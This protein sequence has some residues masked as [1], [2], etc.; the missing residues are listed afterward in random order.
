MAGLGRSARRFVE[1]LLGDPV[2]P[3]PGG[4]KAGPGVLFGVCVGLLLITM[5][6]LILSYE[7]GSQMWERMFYRVML[8]PGD[9]PPLPAEATKV[10]PGPGQLIEFARAVLV[11]L[12]FFLIV[13]GRFFSTELLALL[14]HAPWADLGPR[15]LGLRSAFR[16][17]FVALAVWLSVSTITHHL[18][19]GPRNLW[20]CNGNPFLQKHLEAGAAAKIRELQ[21]RP[22]DDPEKMNGEP[23]APGAPGYDE[24][25]RQCVLPYRL[26][27]PY[28]FVM[29]VLVGPIV[30]TVCF[31]SVFSSLWAHLMLQPQQVERLSVRGPLEEIENRVRYYKQTYK[32]NVDK[33]LLM[34]LILLSYWAY[35]LW[36]DRYNLTAA[37]DDH[38]TRII[39]VALAGWAGLFAAIVLAYQ[40]LVRQAGQRFPDGA[41]RD[42]FEHRHGTFRFF[43][44]TVSG[45]GYALLCLVPIGLAGA[46]YALALNT[47]GPR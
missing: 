46:W 10:S 14:P 43:W 45:S 6:S 23:P 40:V 42:G 29:F 25:Y 11:I 26:Y 20:M 38:T 32:D 21:A 28:S 39:L 5:L 3:N 22:A 12:V 19:A 31:Y 30:L 33:Y 2:Y 1:A 16:L 13:I 47:T 9:V 24:Y 34:V 8:S 37:A 7:A 17:V 27:F 41:P 18:S 4:T 35:H 15:T 36:L 44:R